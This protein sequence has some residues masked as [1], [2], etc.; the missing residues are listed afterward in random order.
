MPFRPTDPTHKISGILLRESERARLVD[1]SSID[2]EMLAAPRQEWFPVSQTATC[3]TFPDGRIELKISRWIYLQ[4]KLDGLVTAAEIPEP[5][6]DFPEHLDI[7]DDP[8]YN[9]PPF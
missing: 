1:I 7:N 3:S 8:L 6:N 2:D 5:Q 9:D 4:K